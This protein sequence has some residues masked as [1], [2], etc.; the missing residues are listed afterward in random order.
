M[1]VNTLIELCVQ[2]TDRKSVR[3]FAEQLGIAHGVMN[4]W[5]N[6]KKPIPEERI[7]QF[8]KFAQLDPGP[9]LLLIKSEQDTGDLGREWAKL[10]KKLGMTVMAVLLCIGSALPG[11]AEAHRPA[12]LHHSLQA[13][14]PHSLYIMRN[15][16]LGDMG[17]TLLDMDMDMDLSVLSIR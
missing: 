12:E 5:K 11:R 8:A 17:A 16:V 1:H 7:R 2:R 13:D 10:Y 6:G 3:A 14:N 4:D 15:D 9:W